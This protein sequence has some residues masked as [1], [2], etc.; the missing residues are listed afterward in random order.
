MW[1]Y[2][3]ET[4]TNIDKFFYDQLQNKLAEAGD[5]AYVK[6]EFWSSSK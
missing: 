5:T 2:G 6:N 1:L 4:W 3:F